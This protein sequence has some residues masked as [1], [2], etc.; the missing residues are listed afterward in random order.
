M[1]SQ[2][3]F[4]HVRRIYDI[5]LIDYLKSFFEDR[6][7]YPTNFAGHVSMTDNEIL[8]AMRNAATNPGAPGHDSAKRIMTHDHFRRVYKRNPSDQAKNAE[9]GKAIY[10]ALCDHCRKNSFVRTLYRSGTENFPVPDGQAN[11]IFYG[12]IRTTAGAICCRLCL[13][14]PE[15]GMMQQNS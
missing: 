14:S 8:S 10:E 5:H 6:G 15:K 11:G 2:L 7:G 1:F 13:S 12:S 9:A 4:H 3:Y